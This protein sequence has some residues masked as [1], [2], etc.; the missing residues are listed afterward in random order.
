MRRFTTGPRRLLVA[1]LVG[2][3]TGGA[4][5]APAAA[6]ADD[7]DGIEIGVT[8]PGESDGPFTVSNA[9]FR[10][11]L[12]PETG[13]G[14]FY[15]GCNFISAGASGDAGGAIV[16]TD[17][18]FF[19]SSSGAVT[20][21]KP[22]AVGGGAT[23]YRTM[24]W[25]DR[26]LDP[27][28]N[29]VVTSD[30][31]S[32]GVQAVIEEGTGS[33]DPGAGTAEITWEGAFTVVF[34]GGM[35]YWWVAD[36]VLTIENGT[37]TVTATAGGY[38][39]S[40]NDLTKWV[41]LEEREIV[42]ADLTGVDLSSG[43]GFSTIPEFLGVEVDLPGGSPPQVTDKDT[44]GSFPQSFVDFQ[45]ETGQAAYWHSSGGLRDPAKP[46]SRLYVSYDADAPLAPDE[47]DPAPAL[48]PLDPPGNLPP[49]TTTPLP[50][51]GTLPP[52]QQGPAPVTGGSPVSPQQVP[53]QQ[54]E[55]SEA[56]ALAAAEA[57]NVLYPEDS[58]L[59]PTLRGLLADPRQRLAWALSAVFTLTGLTYIGL[60]RG[61]LVLPWKRTTTP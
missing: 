24:P 40:M 30:F 21:E 47:P 60:R 1:T 3:L 38:G 31:R 8:I 54:M 61:W 48:P 7:E 37:G 22:Y 43:V 55:P 4:L 58:G 23:E 26:C 15:G 12:N 2:T 39:A 14:A 29:T 51:T 13:S 5:L 17:D 57:L 46:T 42:L 18:E 53:P 59:I 33:V 36:P 41:P 11:G 35:T 49:G 10:W 52:A 25:E 19:A 32:T 16:W 44:W 34:Y 6:L 9:E 50:G 27:E 28:G 56:A 20:V 45:V